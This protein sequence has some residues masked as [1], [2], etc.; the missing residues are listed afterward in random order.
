VNC[1]KEFST[2][3]LLR[4]RQTSWLHPPLRP[5]SARS[6]RH[7]HPQRHS[8]CR[9]ASSS[10]LRCKT[11]FARQLRGGACVACGR[12]RSS[13][14]EYC[15]RTC[16]TA[17]LNCRR[18]QG[19]R[20]TSPPAPSSA[21]ALGA[22]RAAAGIGIRSA[23]YAGTLNTAKT[24]RRAESEACCMRPI[25]KVATL[26]ASIACR[27]ARIVGPQRRHRFLHLSAQESGSDASAPAARR[28]MG[29]C[30]RSCS[31]PERRNPTRKTSTSSAHSRSSLPQ[32]AAPGA[33][34][35]TAQGCTHRQCLTRFFRV[36]CRESASP[37]AQ[38][39][40]QQ[41]LGWGLVPG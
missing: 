3:P 37:G 27:T 11:L 6:S 9:R 21:S 35:Y 7:W 26:K 28:V 13:N 12:S 33:V 20:Q 14:P 30:T 19:L 10:T 24:L 16:A 4:L 15:S 40:W 17:A 22:A 29:P 31:A 1:D 25:T 23:K 38:P 36:L 41:E 8:T 18:C 39:R 32:T 34:L 2:L 5:R